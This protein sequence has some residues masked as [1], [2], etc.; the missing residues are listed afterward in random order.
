[1]SDHY[2]LSIILLFFISIE[3]FF[4]KADFAIF[5][6]NSEEVFDKIVMDI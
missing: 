6:F 5:I 2:I 1:M 4:K 3:I